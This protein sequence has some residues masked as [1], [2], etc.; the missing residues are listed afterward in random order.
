MDAKLANRLEEIKKEDINLA[1]SLTLNKRQ[2]NAVFKRIQKMKYAIQNTLKQHKDFL[3]EFENNDF[4]YLLENKS[5]HYYGMTYLE[6][7][8]TINET[9]FYPKK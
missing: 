4:K 7:F 1:L 5:D 9:V 6:Y 3:I 8:L 2:I